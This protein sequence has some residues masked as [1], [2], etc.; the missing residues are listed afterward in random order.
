[1]EKQKGVEGG[2]FYSGDL[3]DGILLDTLRFV[4]MVLFPKVRDA[5]CLPYRGDGVQGE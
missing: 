3:S 5:L 4:D 1:M 2:V